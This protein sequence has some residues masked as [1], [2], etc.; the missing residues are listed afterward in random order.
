MNR[1]TLFWIVAIGLVAFGYTALRSAT[2]DVAILRT[3]TA[4]FEDRYTSLWFVEDGSW[5]WLRAATP[6]RRW[7]AD[8]RP[9]VAVQVELNG[10]AGANYRAAVIKDGETQKRLNARMRAKYGHADWLR[11]LV[12]G[13]DTV[14]IQPTPAGSGIE[15]N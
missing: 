11:E 13:R 4:D 9:E 3:K 12:L 15:L 1:T 8:L 2:S 14:A 7:L 10:G 6:D 5:I